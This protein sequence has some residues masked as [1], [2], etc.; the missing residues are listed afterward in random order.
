MESQ[1]SIWDR[2]V[3]KLGAEFGLKLESGVEMKIGVQFSYSCGC[4]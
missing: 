2:R 3:R 4:I 1:C